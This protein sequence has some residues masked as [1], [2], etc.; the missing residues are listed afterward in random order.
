MAETEQSQGNQTSANPYA[1]P[2]TAPVREPVPRDVVDFGPIIRR[3]EK[4]RLIYNA[5]LSVEVLLL[6]VVTV[7][8]NLVDIGFW[9]A[10]MA[11]AVGANICFTFGP[12]VE[13]YCTFLRIWHSSFTLLLFLAGLFLAMM[14]AYTCVVNF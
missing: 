13:G 3:W 2:P 7:P 14:L 11:G 12:A 9:V 8:Q 1:A 10:T 6:C 5:I 4:L